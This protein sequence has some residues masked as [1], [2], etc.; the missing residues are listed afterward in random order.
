MCI[1][2][3]AILLLLDLAAAAGMPALQALLADL[4]PRAMRGRI[5]GARML[6]ANLSS[7]FVLPAIGAIYE[8]ARPEAL[9]FIASPCSLIAGLLVAAL[10]REPV[11]REV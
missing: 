9:F 3:R 5:Y 6:L 8:G 4:T 11:R 10:V 1:R 2:D 7:A